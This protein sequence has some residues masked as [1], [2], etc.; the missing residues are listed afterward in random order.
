MFQLF[1]SVECKRHWTFI[2]LTEKREREKRKFSRKKE[3]LLTKNPSNWILNCFSRL[4][5][6]TGLY[7]CVFLAPDIN[8]VFW[9]S[10]EIILSYIILNQI[11]RTSNAWL[12]RSEFTGLITCGTIKD[13]VYGCHFPF[14]ARHNSLFGLRCVQAMVVGHVMTE[15]TALFELY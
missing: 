4:P 9:L 14:S 7:R 8:R 10:L 6:W 11:L 3:K 5:V 2:V 1:S 12:N 15:L 13:D